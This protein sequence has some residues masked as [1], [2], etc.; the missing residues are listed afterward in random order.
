MSNRRGPK[1]YDDDDGRTIVNMDVEGMPWYDRRI[2]RENRKEA[3]AELERKVAAG[4]AL[5]RAES[6]RYSFYAVLGALTVVGVIG[7]GVVLFILLLWLL[8]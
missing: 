4:E 3:K 7:G 5:T 6:R 2:N 1:Q 8:W